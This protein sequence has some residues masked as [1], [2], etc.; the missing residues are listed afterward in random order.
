[1]IRFRTGFAPSTIDRMAAQIAEQQNREA[2]RKAH[3][4]GELMEI[5]ARKTATESRRPGV[6]TDRTQSTRRSFANLITSGT[7]RTAEGWRAYLTTVADA[8]D[9]EVKK[10]AA[11]E[12]GTR[13][14]YPIRARRSQFL[15]GWTWQG[16][17]KNNRYKNERQVFTPKV[18][19]PGSAPQN[20]LRKA[21]DRVYQRIRRGTV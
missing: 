12:Y 17:S 19:H 9:E 15:T 6:D 21:R 2:E 4:A 14:N 18:D 13:K 20:V 8:T 3:R 16:P 1:M 5:E 11:I 7:E 10:V